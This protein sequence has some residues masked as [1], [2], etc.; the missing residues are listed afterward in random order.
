MDDERPPF[1]RLL[2]FATIATPLALGITLIGIGLF[3][4]AFAFPLYALLEFTEA[5]IAAGMA[6]LLAGL[7]YGLGAR[8][9]KQKVWETPGSGL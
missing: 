1:W 6:H 2:F 9:W 8:W 5:R 7:T 3:A 4:G